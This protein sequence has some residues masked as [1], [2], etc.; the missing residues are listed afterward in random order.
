M[1]SA[2]RRAA[3]RAG[4]APGEVRL[5]AV[6]K[7]FPAE[8]RTRR[9]S[10][11]AS[12]PSAR[13]TCRRPSQA[14]GAGGPVGHRVAA[15]RPVAG[16]QGGLAARAFDAVES[17][18]R[19]RIAQ[20][21][22]AARASGLTLSPR[23]ALDVLVQVNI[24]GEA[25]KQRRARSTTRCR[26]RATCRGCPR[27]C[28]AASWASP[29]RTWRADVQRAQFRALRHC[30]EAARADGLARRHAVDGHE[31][32]PGGGDRRRCDRGAHR[33][34]AVRRETRGASDRASAKT[35]TIRWHDRGKAADGHPVHREAATWR[36]R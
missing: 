32:R 33:F 4:R 8:A 34:G 22:S 14:R 9:V 29:R 27:W 2:H 17:V 19:L 26:S 20:R 1:E 36:R 30:F 28:C 6:S 15:D 25:T 35:R 7:T 12:A 5:L 10:P 24:S 21:L 18:D 23:P 16:Q 11:A 31:R 3:R 13:I